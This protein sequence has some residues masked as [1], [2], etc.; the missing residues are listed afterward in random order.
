MSQ[1]EFCVCCYLRAGYSNQQ[2]G[3]ATGVGLRCVQTTRYRLRKKLPIASSS[4]TGHIHS[5]TQKIV[6]MK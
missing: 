6:L 5:H 4:A 3:E 1:S 2:I